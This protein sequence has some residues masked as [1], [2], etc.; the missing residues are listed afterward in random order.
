MFFCCLHGLVIR[1]LSRYSLPQWAS[2]EEV[3]KIK[4][5][6]RNIFAQCHM[7]S[8]LGYSWMYTVNVDS[9]NLEFRIRTLQFKHLSFCDL[10][11]MSKMQ[12]W[13]S[14]PQLWDLSNCFCEFLLAWVWRFSELM[15]C[16]QM[17]NQVMAISKKTWV[18]D[19]G[20]V[21]YKDGLKLGWIPALFEEFVKS[22]IQG[23]SA[24]NV[25]LR[26]S[27]EACHYSYSNGLTC[28]CY[29]PLQLFM[30]KIKML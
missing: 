13:F 6:T 19:L 21:F 8:F 26:W 30:V 12:M 17:E 24:G 29:W 14:A 4:A 7:S 9:F 23:R 27:E 25:V 11:Q 18:W 10:A 16:H 28:L 15:D 5:N 1:A 3:K 20:F 22:R 2:K